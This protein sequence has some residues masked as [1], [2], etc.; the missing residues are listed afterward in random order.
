MLP[1][2]GSPLRSL[3]PEVVSECVHRRKK[4]LLPGE[5]GAH[6]M[7]AVEGE[8]F[9]VDV[10]RDLVAFVGELAFSKTGLAKDSQPAAPA[11][12]PKR[13]RKRKRT[14][15][16]SRIIYLRA[17]ESSLHQSGRRVSGRVEH[18]REFVTSDRADAMS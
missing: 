7:G 16:Q 18:E 11:A 9:N 8:R 15:E 13:T 17:E 10:D 5:T 3:R 2:Y 4:F 1:N 14:S 12:P 6:V